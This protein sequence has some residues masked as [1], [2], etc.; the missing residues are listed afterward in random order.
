MVQ[1]TVTPIGIVVATLMLVMGCSMLFSTR[2]WLKLLDDYT[3]HPQRMLMPGLAMTVFGLIVV[4]NHNIWERGWLVVIT[5]AGWLVLIK[6]LAFLFGP[7]LIELHRVFSP[8]IIKVSMRTGGTGL[9]LI[10]IM[11]LLVLTGRA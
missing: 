11:L 1:D 2:N 8:G 9:I 6:G 10:S 5:V 3:G 4:F 7:K